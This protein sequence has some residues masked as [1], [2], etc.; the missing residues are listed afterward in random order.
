MLKIPKLINCEEKD[1]EKR[2]TYQ[3][4][5]LFNYQEINQITITDH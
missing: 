5:I 4:K 3:I 2:Y 1:G